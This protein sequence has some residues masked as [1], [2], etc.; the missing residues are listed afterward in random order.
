[1]LDTWFW[2]QQSLNL[3]VTLISCA[4]LDKSVN[5]SKPQIPLLPK[6]DNTC[7]HLIWMVLGIK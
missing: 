7:T 4:P 3:G 5:L 6:E 2:N 1:M